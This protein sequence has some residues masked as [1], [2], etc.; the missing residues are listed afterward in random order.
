MRAVVGTEARCFR[1]G[2]AV[3]PQYQ[4]L[5]FLTTMRVTLFVLLGFPAWSIASG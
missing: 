1:F 2:A 5:T 3:Y 4:M